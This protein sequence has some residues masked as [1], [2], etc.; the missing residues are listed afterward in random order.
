[1]SRSVVTCARA[2]GRWIFTTT[3]S[4]LTSR[5]ACTWA[6]D[7]AA[8]GAGSISAKTSAMGRPSSAAMAASASD[9]GMGDE[10]IC[11]VE[12]ASMNAGG[13]TSS[14]E[15][16]TWPSLMKVTPASFIAATSAFGRSSSSPSP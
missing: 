13:R 15:E 1:M 8:R 14:L 11:S 3:S 6:T 2:C 9:H 12:K 7:A 5:A 16:S 4:P 10:S